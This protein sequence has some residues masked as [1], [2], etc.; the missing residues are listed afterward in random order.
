MKVAVCYSGQIGA[1]H[2]AHQFQRASFLK[3][4]MDVYAY[5]S[6]LISQKTNKIPNYKP[7]SDVHAYLPAGKGWRK[8]QGEYGIIYRI[9]YETKAKSMSLINPKIEKAVD[10]KQELEESQ[11]G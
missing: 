5:T 8:N 9:P 6:D 4:D 10:E 7:S 2:K 11:Q 1:L 3:D